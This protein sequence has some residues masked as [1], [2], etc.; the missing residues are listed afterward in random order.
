MV[1]SNSLHNDELILFLLILQE[2]FDFFN[3]LGQLNH[4][5]ELV[6]LFLLLSELDQL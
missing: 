2:S 3:T 1:V 5:L 6:G 4:E